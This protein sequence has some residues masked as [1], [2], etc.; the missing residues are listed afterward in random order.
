MNAEEVGINKLRYL[1]S[2]GSARESIRKGIYAPE[3]AVQDG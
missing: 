3:G 1:V 2:G